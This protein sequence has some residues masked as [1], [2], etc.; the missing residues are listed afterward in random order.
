MACSRF[1]ARLEQRSTAGTEISD[2]TRDFLAA[3]P[4]PDVYASSN[5]VVV[6]EVAAVNASRPK[7]LGS[8]VSLHPYPEKLKQCSLSASSL[9]VPKDDFGEVSSRLVDGWCPNML[10]TAIFRCGGTNPIYEV[11]LGLID[12]WCPDTWKWPVSACRGTN[13]IYKVISGL[14]DEWCPNTWKWPASH[15][16]V[17]MKYKV[18]PGPSL[19]NVWRWKK[20]TE[21]ETGCTVG[22]LEIEMFMRDVQCWALLGATTCSQTI[23]T[24]NE[25]KI[26]LHSEKYQT[27]WNTMLVVAGGI[28]RRWGGRKLRKSDI[29]CMEDADDL[30]LKEEKHVREWEEEDEDQEEEEEE[31]GNGGRD[32]VGAAGETRQEVSWIWTTMGLSG[33][34]TGL[35][36]GAFYLLELLLDTKRGPSASN[37]IGE[38]VCPN[39]AVGRGIPAAADFPRIPSSGVGE[40]IEGDG[41]EEIDESVAQGLITYAAKQAKMFWNITAR[42]E[43]TKTELAVAKGKRHPGEPILNPLAAT[44][45]GRPAGDRDEKDEE[46]DEDE[47][48][49]LMKKRSRGV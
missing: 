35:E 3:T 16:G 1:L 25:S 18:S 28:R 20:S 31:E 42:V 5:N 30:A 26:R 9:V 10:K 7:C 27:A 17:A 33:T 46:N 15:K 13:P 41:S 11:T 36:D 22:L 43:T 40:E 48:G 21:R 34:D 45:L 49:V 37:R 47:T 2:L 39:E 14:I 29:R 4:D 6:Q 12:G 24:Q 19:Q 44:T 38:I 32:Q 8:S 23:V